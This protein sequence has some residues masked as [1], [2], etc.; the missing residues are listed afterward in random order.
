VA[1]SAT[2]VRVAAAL[3]AL[4]GLSGCDGDV[5]RLGGGACTHGQ[6]PANQ[7]LW[8][9]DSWQL[10]PAGAEPHTDVLAQARA[11]SAAG[12]SDTYTIGAA[13][14]AS[15]TTIATQYQSHEA[16]TTKVKVLIMDG[17]TWDTFISTDL[18]TTVT[19]VAA[20]FNDLLATVA[21]DG[22]VTSV[23]YFLMPELTD[24]PGI[25]SIPGVAELRPLLEQSCA[26][27]TVACYFI[28]LQK[29][30]TNPT[31][32]TTSTSPPVPT[33]DGAKVI[34]DQ[35]WSIMQTNCIAQ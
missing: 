8:I 23:I 25:T 1:R 28:D 6:V 29:F 21:S 33:A 5:I 3:A 26:Q 22:T 12:A 34:A 14:A 10:V 17:G 7:V 11:A 30:W 27:S 31:D 32:Y 15:M 2:V 18:A 35:I 24:I 19:S 16:S 4:V 13:A 20:S 9:G